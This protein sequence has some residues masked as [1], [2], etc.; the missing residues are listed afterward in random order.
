MTIQARTLY[1]SANGDTWS[2]CRNPNGDVLVSHR[3]NRASGGKP[4]EIDLGSFLAKANQGPE[5][6]AL[7]QLIGELIESNSVPAEYD[8]HD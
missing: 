2:L 5:H 8:D 7:R 4:A 1:T 3:P 6:Q